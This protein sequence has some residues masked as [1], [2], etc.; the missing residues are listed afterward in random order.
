MDAMRSGLLVLALM[1]FA[2]AA[3]GG[4]DNATTVPAKTTTAQPAATPAPKQGGGGAAV[5][6]PSYVAPA[7]K[8]KT[9]TGK[10]PAVGLL[11][12]TGNSPAAAA[13]AKRLADLGIAWVIVIVTR[14]A[15]VPDRSGA[16][17]KAVT[18]AE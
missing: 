7:V 1:P 16:F 14:P 10:S 3:C 12:D 8:L 2:V 13:E 6:A 15:T 9:P 11:P 18:R 17:N 4:T 5:A